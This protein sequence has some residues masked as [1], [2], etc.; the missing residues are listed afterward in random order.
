MAMEYADHRSSL[1]FLPAFPY[2]TVTC[3]GVV[4][5]KKCRRTDRDEATSRSYRVH[6][7]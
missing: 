3:M 1:V 2:V 5:V 7:I 6:E 4:E